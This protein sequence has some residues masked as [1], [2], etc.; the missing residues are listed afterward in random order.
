MSERILE[1]EFAVIP[2]VLSSEDGTVE[3]VAS[4]ESL[5]SYGDI[6]KAD[7]WRFDAR[8]EKNPVFLDCHSSWSVSDV[9]GRVISKEIKNQQLL[10]VV[11]FAIDVKS[12]K[13]ARLAFDMTEKGYLKAVSVGF[14]PEHSAHRSDEDWTKTLDSIKGLSKEDR[15]KVYRVFIQQQQVEL[16][17]CPIGAN[18]NAV[19]KAFNDGAISEEQLAGVG[20]GTDAGF[21]ALT[22]AAGIFDNPQIDAETKT[23][24]GQ[25]LVTT[26]KQFSKSGKGGR[27]ANTADHGGGAD[28]FYSQMRTHSSNHP[29]GE[30]QERAKREKADREIAQFCD[31]MGSWLSN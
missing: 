24:F 15:D 8:F 25:M 16:S 26:A 12:N 10:E 7:G 29:D 18:P 27:T 28:P 31:A 4:D 23:V 5:D 21:D 2:K 17:N 20:L 22:K 1:R 19:A 30:E 9:I 13:T 14:Y 11:K 3:Y 6:I